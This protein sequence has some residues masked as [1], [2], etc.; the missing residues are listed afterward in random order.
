MREEG[1][2][3]F[4]LLTSESLIKMGSVIASRQQ[5][6]PFG[7]VSRINGARPYQPNLSAWPA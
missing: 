2:V 7:E 5:L 4:C 3:I 6:G 1:R